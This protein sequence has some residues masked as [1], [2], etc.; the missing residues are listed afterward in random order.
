MVIKDNEALNQTEILASLNEEQ[1]TRFHNLRSNTPNAIGGI[2]RYVPDLNLGERMPKSP[3]LEPIHRK[4]SN[5][6]PITRS[7]NNLLLP[8]SGKTNTLKDVFNPTEKFAQAQ[9]MT[10]LKSQRSGLSSYSRRSD[11]SK[12]SQKSQIVS[13]HE[14][15]AE[16]Q[17]RKNRKNSQNKSI[18]FRKDYSP[19]Q[20]ERQN[21]T[22]Y[23]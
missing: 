6:Y 2:G 19:L 23:N 5:Q 17:R 4:D 7:Q 9:L 10:N 21:Q 12:H 11:K 3:I 16:R 15:Q 8:P 13:S 18:G 14:L 22:D 1:D 20:I